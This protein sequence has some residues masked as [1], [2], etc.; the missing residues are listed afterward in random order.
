MP[1]GSKTLNGG[2]LMRFLEDEGWDVALLFVFMLLF[3][4]VL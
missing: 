4:T 2:E 1:P 3:W